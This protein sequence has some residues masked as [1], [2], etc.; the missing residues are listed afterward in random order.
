MMGCVTESISNSK[1]AH[2]SLIAGVGLRHLRRRRF[3]NLFDHPVEERS[4]KRDH[5][6]F[7]HGGRL[8]WIRLLSGTG[9]QRSD[10]VRP[11][12][13]DE[14]DGRDGRLLGAAGI[15]GQILCFF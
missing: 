12:D 14:L 2:G 4:Y 10:H 9:P 1:P 6:L 11:G 15:G 8:R 3:R 13:G 5:I 7:A